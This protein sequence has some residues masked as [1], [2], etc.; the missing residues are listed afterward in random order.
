MKIFKEEIFGPVCS[1]TKFK[2]G[3]GSA[4]EALRIANN[5]E[6]G[7]LGGFFTNDRNKANLMERN[8]QCGQVGNNCYLGIGV[9]VPFGGYKQSGLGREMS[10]ASF[11]NFLETKTVVVDCSTP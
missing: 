11:D 8:M 10:Q 1:I 6:Y 2:S 3:D 7:L 9:D 4:E 5:S